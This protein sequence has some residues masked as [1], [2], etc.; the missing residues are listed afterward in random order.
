MPYDLYK[1]LQ[2]HKCMQICTQI[3]IFK[4]SFLK[5]LLKPTQFA[6][7][8]DISQLFILKVHILA[9]L[10]VAECHRVENPAWARPAI[11]F[12]RS[13]SGVGYHW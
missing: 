3:K 6:T 5:K 7:L 4:K 13:S 9:F 2:A 11:T 8:K 10:F 12:I 1:N